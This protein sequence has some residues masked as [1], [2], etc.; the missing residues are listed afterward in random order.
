MKQEKM[1]RNKGF[2]LVEV[3][4]V[5]VIIGILAAAVM[6]G[7][8]SAEDNAQAAM[9]ISDLRNLKAALLLLYADTGEW[10]EAPAY[11]YVAQNE[12]VL[13]ELHKY[14]DRPIP[15]D[16]YQDIWIRRPQNM[17]DGKIMVG[18]SLHSGNKGVMEKLEGKAA[19]V[20]LVDIYGE[21]YNSRTSKA[22]TASLNTFCMFM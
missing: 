10:P 11:V 8:R 7:S 20:G 1:R 13:A 19:S 12:K 17:S 15:D 6:V 14:M 21:I 3:L 5:I 22:S 9:V 2:T 4:I 16:R 18:V